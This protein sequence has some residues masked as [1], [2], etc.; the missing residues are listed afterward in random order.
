MTELIYYVCGDDPDCF[1]LQQQKKTMISSCPC[2]KFD[3]H[4]QHYIFFYFSFMSIIF[5]L[6]YF[7][8]LLLGIYIFRRTD[9]FISMQY[10]LSLII[11]LV[12]SL[13]CMKVI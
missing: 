8:V 5:C 3:P 7:E 6:I 1:C 9:L 11:L 13:H 4:L 2:K 10:T 12:L